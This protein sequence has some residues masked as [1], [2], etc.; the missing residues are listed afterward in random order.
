MALSPRAASRREYCFEEQQKGS[1]QSRD[2]GRLILDSNHHSRQEVGLVSG[3]ETGLFQLWANYAL[4][5][6]SSWVSRI[7]SWI[8]GRASLHLA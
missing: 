2:R 6:D 7:M 3:D 1:P 8:L 4:S 5:N